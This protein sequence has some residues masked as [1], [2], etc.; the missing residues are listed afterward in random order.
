MQLEYFL[1]RLRCVSVGCAALGLCPPLRCPCPLCL[2]PAPASG[3]R[4]KWV[5]RGRC[6]CRWASATIL[7]PSCGLLC[8]PINGF[9]SWNTGVGWDPPYRHL[10]TH[11]LER[12]HLFCDVCEDVCSCPALCLGH[13]PDSCLVV[14]VYSYLPSLTTTFCIF[15]CYLQCEVDALQLSGVDC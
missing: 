9:V 12:L 8:G 15:L 7:S 14:C 2:C 4:P 1:G 6:V 10:P 5:E 11:F 3:C 13:G